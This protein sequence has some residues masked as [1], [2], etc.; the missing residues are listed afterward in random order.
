VRSTTG[1]AQDEALTRLCRLVFPH[2]FAEEA[3]LWPAVRAALP[4]AE[5]MTVEV[6]R[7]HQE[8]NELMSAVERSHH[9]DAD[10]DE[11]LERAFALLDTDVRD[12]EDELLP[13]LQEALDDREL[14]RLG[15]TWELVR[16]IAPTR[17]HPTVARRPPGNVISA[18]PLSAIDRSRDLLDRVARS[19]PPPVRTVGRSGSGALARLAGAV[20]RLPPVRKGEDPSTHSGRTEVE[21]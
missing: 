20:E 6:E 8:I 14:R 2:A 4:D 5:E 19:G 10:R 16:R 12:E 13:R 17:S 21:T 15:V 11:L 9:E 7:E 18:L 3:V 1:D